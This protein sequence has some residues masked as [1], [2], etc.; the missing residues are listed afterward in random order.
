MKMFVKKTSES[1]NILSIFPV[2]KRRPYVEE[3]KEC[4][5]KTR[6]KKRDKFRFCQIYLG[7]E[8][9]VNFS[10]EEFNTKKSVLLDKIQ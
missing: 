3:S 4:S 9:D 7:L 5:S 6:D 8:T 1:Q 2:G 10:D